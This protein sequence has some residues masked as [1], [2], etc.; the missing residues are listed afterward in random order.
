VEEQSGLL[1][2]EPSLQPPVDALCIEISSTKI[3]KANQIL[4]GQ[5]TPQTGS[6]ETIYIFLSFN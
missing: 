2:P 4:I 1:T 6:G 5:H 3:P